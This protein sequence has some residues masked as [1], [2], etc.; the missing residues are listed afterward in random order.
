MPVPGGTTLEVVEGALP[1]AQELVALTVALVF[2]LDVALER[3]GRAEQVRDHRVVDHQVRRGQRVDLLR[4]AAQFGDGLTHGGEVDDARHTGEVLHDDAGGRVLNFDARFG[5]GIPLG[6]RLDV[7]LGDV[8]AVFIT[9]QV[10][11]E[12]LQ[13]VGQLLYTRNRV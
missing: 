4:V 9:Q 7:V 12:H 1:P 11:G 3:V 13:A 5:L 8:A 10:F 6:D 2:D